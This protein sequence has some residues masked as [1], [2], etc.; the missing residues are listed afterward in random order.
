MIE[1]VMAL[2][3]TVVAGI[4]FSYQE[5]VYADGVDRAWWFQFVV[6]AF[7]WSLGTVISVECFWSWIV[8]GWRLI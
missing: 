5:R 7:P 8:A 4:Y 6:L 2:V 1:L 3:M